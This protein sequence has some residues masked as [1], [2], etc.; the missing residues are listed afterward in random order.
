MIARVV[1]IALAA[2]LSAR[3]TGIFARSIRPQINYPGQ[4]RELRR[5]PSGGQIS[6][7]PGFGRQ[8]L[9]FAVI[10]LAGRKVLRLRL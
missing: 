4:R 7:L 10:T 1:I 8:C 6:A 5:R 3:L 9:V 2:A